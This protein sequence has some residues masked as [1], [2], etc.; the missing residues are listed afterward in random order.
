MTDRD[1]VL[2]AI[3]KSGLSNTQFARQIVARDGRQVRRWLAGRPV[4]HAVRD[5]LTQYLERPQP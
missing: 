4:P 2:A 3:R 1:L 5:W